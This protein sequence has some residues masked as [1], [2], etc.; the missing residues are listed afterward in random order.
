MERFKTEH[1]CLAWPTVFTGGE[2]LPSASF[3][4]DLSS[5]TGI[6]FNTTPCESTYQILVNSFVTLPKEMISEFEE[7]RL[8]HSSV[9]ALYPPAVP[10]NGH[11]TN[12]DNADPKNG[13]R[14]DAEK[15]KND[16]TQNERDEKLVAGSRLPREE[17]G[18]L[19]LSEMIATLR[20]PSY[21]VPR[22]RRSAYEEGLWTLNSSECFGERGGFQTKF[23]P[24]ATPHTLMGRR[25]PGYTCY[26]ALFKLTLGESPGYASS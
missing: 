24:G 17:D 4:L 1:D 3:R 9:D 18:I 8:V 7:S 2:Y 13:H 21:T 23:E 14:D 26:T 19:S 15:P 6:D 5:H 20:E 12:D 11:V 16:S 10:E 25:E 22:K